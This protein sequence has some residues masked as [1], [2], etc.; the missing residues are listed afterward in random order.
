MDLLPGPWPDRVRAERLLGGAPADPRD[1]AETRFT[2]VV[3]AVAALAR[4]C[5]VDPEREQA[6]L[7]AFRAARR[8]PRHRS[9]RPA[10]TQATAGAGGPSGSGPYPGAGN[11]HGNDG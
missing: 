11:D 10:G 5:A 1:P 2:E 4:G 6:A 8:R 7:A 9:V 3:R